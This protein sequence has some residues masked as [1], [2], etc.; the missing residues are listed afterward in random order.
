MAATIILHPGVLVGQFTYE[1][2]VYYEGSGIYPRFES[3]TWMG[4]YG[5]YRTIINTS[6]PQV[7]NYVFLGWSLNNDNKPTIQ[8]GEEISIDDQYAQVRLYACWSK[9]TYIISFNGNAE[10]VTNLPNSIVKNYN[11][12]VNLSTL[13]PIRN[14]YDFIGWATSLTATEPEYQPGDIF[15][16]N[17]DTILYAVW[18]LKS[19]SLTFFS[20][21]G[22]FES[23]SISFVKSYPVNTILN[24]TDFNTDDPLIKNRKGYNFIGWNTNAVAK[25]G[26]EQYIVTS[27]N[28]Q[29]LYAI[30][31]LSSN[32]YIYINNSWKI[33]IP[34]VYKDGMWKTAQ[35][36][37]YNGEW[38]Q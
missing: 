14:N 8:I 11:S 38:S 24:L 29:S 23:G 37:I 27:S 34:Y 20:N 15:T 4:P 28:L 12:S 5:G 30:W 10:G 3:R 17:K 19:Y 9:S 7:N 21:G 35:S 16:T 31:E 22:N 1:G 25:E 18:T 6:V 2:Q 13:I 26:L 36:K 33:A 32:A